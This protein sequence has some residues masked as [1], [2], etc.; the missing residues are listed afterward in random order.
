MNVRG[1]G[2]L[3]LGGLGEPFRSLLFRMLLLGD[4]LIE[5]AHPGKEHGNKPPP[6]GRTWEKSKGDATCPTDLPEHSLLE[7]IL[8]G[9]CGCHQKGP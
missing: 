9:Q 7:S 3:G 5:T 4:V 8:T 1:G 6:T 2:L